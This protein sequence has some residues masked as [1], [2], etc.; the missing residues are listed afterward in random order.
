[1]EIQA[2]VCGLVR[3]KSASHLT[4]PVAF[5]VA[6]LT[7][8]I[9]PASAQ[10]SNAGTFKNLTYEQTGPST[11]VSTGAYFNAQAFFINPGDYTSATLN[12]PGPLSP[13]NLPAISPTGFGIGPS[14]PTQ[15]AMD[16]AYPF[17]AYSIALTGGNQPGTVV[18]LPDYLADAYTSDVPK[19]TAASFNAL[20]GLSTAASSLTLN[21]NSFTPSSLTTTAFTFFSIFDSSQGCTFLSPSATG[22]TINPTALTAGKTYNWELDFSGRIEANANGVLTY[23]DF[24]VRTDGTFQTAVPEASTWAMLIIG[25]AGLGFMRYRRNNAATAA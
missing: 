12:N 3:S 22:C 25:F 9:S 24:D 7:G 15:A 4:L 18:N 19:L 16:L 17:G 13:Q 2:K 10:V 23:T 11:V 6:A 8:A 5:G 20:Q 14:F 1:M 21:F